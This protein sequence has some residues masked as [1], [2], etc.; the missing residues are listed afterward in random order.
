MVSKAFSMAFQDFL[1]F[2]YRVVRIKEMGAVWAAM[3]AGEWAG[4]FGKASQCKGQ[5]RRRVDNVQC[6]KRI[7]RQM[8]LLFYCSTVHEC[9]MTKWTV[10]VCTLHRLPSYQSSYWWT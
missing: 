6:A 5:E 8:I 1:G 3:L 2:F 10:A 9:T 4:R 7:H